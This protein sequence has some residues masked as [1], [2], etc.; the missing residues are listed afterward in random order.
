MDVKPTLKLP[1]APRSPMK[2]P[3]APW[4]SL[5]WLLKKNE[6]GKGW[7]LKSCLF[8]QYFRDFTWQGHLATTKSSSKVQ[9]RILKVQIIQIIKGAYIKFLGTSGLSYL[10]IIICLHFDSNTKSYKYE[11]SYNSVLYKFLE[12]GTS[13]R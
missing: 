9:R 4:S 13:C 7:S 1:D 3:E 12:T 10:L 5:K 6:R 8:S 2:P 11:L